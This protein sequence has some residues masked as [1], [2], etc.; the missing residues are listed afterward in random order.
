MSDSSR[1]TMIESE[2]KAKLQEHYKLEII[3]NYLEQELRYNKT[4]Q[5]QI[6]DKILDL[7]SKIGSS[8]DTVK[9]EESDE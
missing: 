4:R 3:I 9:T 8:N 2:I 7:K 5:N 6:G 1:H